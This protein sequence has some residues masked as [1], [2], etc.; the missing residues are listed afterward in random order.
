MEWGCRMKIMG[1]WGE[2]KRL[3]QGIQEETAKIKGDI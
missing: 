2:E 3:C 1:E